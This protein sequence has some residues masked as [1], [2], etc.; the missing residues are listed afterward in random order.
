VSPRDSLRVS[1][2]F[3][4]S[5]PIV[6]VV[7]GSYTMNA[8]FLVP[9]VMHPIMILMHNI[10]EKVIKGVVDSSLR[11]PSAW[12]LSYDESMEKILVL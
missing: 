7:G 1:F 12:Y 9:L 2:F 4:F 6:S 3:K 5:C 11:F 8:G 10:L